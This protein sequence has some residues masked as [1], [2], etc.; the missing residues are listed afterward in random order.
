MSVEEI[1]ASKKEFDY[2]LELLELYNIYDDCDRRNAI[3]KSIEKHILKLLKFLFRKKDK[4][5]FIEYF[6]IILN[7]NI[8]NDYYNLLIY[9]FIYDSLYDNEYYY[10]LF[11]SSFFKIILKSDNKEDIIN[12]L[13]QFYKI[14]YKSFEY[15]SI[16]NT[17]KHTFINTSWDDFDMEITTDYILTNEFIFTYKLLCIYYR[18]FIF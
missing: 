2:I 7:Y 18:A 17:F 6:T 12:I 10:H 1:S 16:Y 11:M 15:D 3:K 9:I 14:N 13:I 8:I 4:I 5:H